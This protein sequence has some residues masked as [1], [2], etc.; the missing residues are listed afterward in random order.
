[1]IAKEKSDL[2]VIIQLQAVKSSVASSIIELSK[3]IIESEGSD[4]TAVIQ[5]I[6]KIVI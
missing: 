1:M 3:S 5:K 6:L 2:E 4:K